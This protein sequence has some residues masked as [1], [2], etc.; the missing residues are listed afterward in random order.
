MK[1]LAKEL[2]PGD[3]ISIWNR[4]CYIIAVWPSHVTSDAICVRVFV[5]PAVVNQI[6]YMKEFQ[7]FF[8]EKQ[9]VEVLT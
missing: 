8:I 6:T 4:R 2:V 3:V 9:T 5:S 7:T 1:K